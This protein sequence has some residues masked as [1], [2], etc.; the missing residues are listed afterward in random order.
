MVYHAVA[1]YP[2]SCRWPKSVGLSKP[3]LHTLPHDQL[4]AKL[5]SL[6]NLQAVRDSSSDTGWK[7]DIGP[8]PGWTVVSDW[9]P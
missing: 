8:F 9:Q 6:T 4:L 2:P 3:P 1:P 5:R 7:I